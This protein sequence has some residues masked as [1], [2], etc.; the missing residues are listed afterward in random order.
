MPPAAE[1]S[2]P[3]AEEALPPTAGTLPA[4]DD[5]AADQPSAPVVASEGTP[6]G[7]SSEA[8]S[9]KPSPAQSIQLVIAKFM[10]RSWT[11][12]QGDDTVKLGV[13]MKMKF[14]LLTAAIEAARPADASK[15]DGCIA[16]LADVSNAVVEKSSA[17]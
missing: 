9:D 12:F 17:A 7:D 4:S 10:A 3:P 16:K 5:A 8:P 14:Q 2:P 6:S 1:T 13:S 11:S 15:S